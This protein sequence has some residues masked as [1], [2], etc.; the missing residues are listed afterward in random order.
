MKKMEELY[1]K[2]LQQVGENPEREGLVRTPERASKAMR[3]LTSG[4]SKKIEDVVNGAL[5]DVDSNQMVMVKDI[6]FYSLCEH[7]ILPFYGT[8]TVA[9]IPNGKV[10][11]LSKLPRIVDMYAR[12]LQVQERLTNEI[13]EAVL[14]VTNAKGVIV[15]MQAKHLCVMMRG[16]EK[17]CDTVTKC[18]LGDIS[19]SDMHEFLL[20]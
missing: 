9:Y 12:R 4:Y 7:H 19:S 16:V 13:A 1:L 15:T 3:F 5:F 11:G 2:L 8:C 20:L 14:E 18:T 17:N 6:E 10:I